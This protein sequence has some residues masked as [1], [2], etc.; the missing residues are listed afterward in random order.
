MSD[1]PGLPEPAPAFARHF[2][3]PIYDDVADDL[4][5]F[6]SDEGSDLLATW[7]H[8]RQELDPS[9]TLATV[10]ECD[11]SEVT[12]YTGPM[13]GVDGLETA[14]FV[15]S[16]A[17]VL[18]RLVGH[19]SDDDRQVAL[20]ALDFQVRVLGEVDAAHAEPPRTL[21]TQRDD[22]TSWRNPE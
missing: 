8:R 22:L 4:A 10:L 12:R 3:D 17:F 9:S 14:S 20:Q 2:T 18:L 21:L 13:S 11:P 1:L 5:P 7:G 19:L 15:V 16:A 6:G